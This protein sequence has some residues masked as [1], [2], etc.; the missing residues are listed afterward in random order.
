M[1]KKSN[2]W[3]ELLT[4]Y[5]LFSSDVS[6]ANKVCVSPLQYQSIFKITGFDSEKFLQGQLSCDM[7]EVA[8]DRSRLA[9]HCNPKGSM[10]SLMRLA[11]FK[12]DYY[13]KVH[14]DN[15][16]DTIANLK[17]YMMFSKAE[18]TEL[19]NRWV[20]F[21]I[22]GEQAE[23]YLYD[24]FQD[25]PQTT[26]AIVAADQM[27]AIKVFG[28]RYELWMSADKAR[29]WLAADQTQ[30]LE[31]ISRPVT[32][33]LVSPK[34]WQS[35]EITQGIPDIVPASSNQYIPQ[36]CNLQ[37]LQGVSFQK[38]CYTGQE[39]ITRLHFRGKLNKFLIA[40]SADTDNTD[41]KITIGTAVHCDDRDNI[42]KVL[43]WVSI[44]NKTYLQLVVNVKY[45]QSALFIDKNLT[46]NTLEQ[47]YTVDPAL[48]IRK[49]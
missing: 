21:G 44:S 36:M 49:D 24:L 25:I 42:A 31:K 9:A 3:K 40:A 22:F 1:I 7:R 32:I 15:A 26:N 5:H 47:A 17:K 28:N 27:F 35:Q 39:I 10:L 12:G 18:L 2:L 29:E 33:S 41:Q 13:L 8:S 43:Q 37:A 23:N 11:Y 16:L 30:T 14:S 6:A 4:K 34:I 46:L 48:F 19:E 45:A 38:G 20:A